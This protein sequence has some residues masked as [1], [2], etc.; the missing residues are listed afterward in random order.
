MGENKMRREKDFLGE[1]EIPAEALYGIHALRASQNFPGNI[2]F[3]LVWY[4]ATAQVKL[5]YYLSLERFIES[6]DA[7]GLAESLPFPLP[8]IAQVRALQEAARE[9]SAGK[10]F[11]AFILPGLNGGAGTSINMNINEII[12]NRALQILG[13]VPGEYDQLD[14]VLHANIFQSTNDVI[15][16]ALKLAVMNMLEILEEKIN[17]LRSGIEQKEGENRNVLRMGHTQ[18]QEAV[19]GSW[20]K[21]F[22]AYSEAFSRDWWRVTRSMERIKVLN[23]GGGATGTGLSI[24]RFII[25]DVIRQLQKLTGMPLTR[26]ENLPDATSNL[27]TL[28]EVHGMLKSLAVNLEKMA[29]DLRMLSSDLSKQGLRLPA[30]QAGSS[31]MPGKVNPVIPE[32]LISIAHKVYAND[33]LITRLIGQG[34]LELNAYIPLIGTAMLESLEL[35]CDACEIAGKKMIKGMEVDEGLSGEILY[36]SPSVTTALIPYIGY[37]IAGELAV[38]MKDENIDIFE[39]A[40][41]SG[42]VDEEVLKNVMKPENLL[43]LGYSLREI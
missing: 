12:T 29:S 10:H 4:K 7:E 6:V 43:K 41:K 1:L 27:D 13:K 32:Y 28:A 35:L 30:V 14:P 17:Q 20:G 8:R 9:M 33:G 5:A 3:S 25:M 31:I 15:P 36:K 39:A 11:T 42:R 22:S 21:L 19:P 18:M 24:P 23:L 2:P 16:S 38:L 40:R 26:S 37:H 34:C